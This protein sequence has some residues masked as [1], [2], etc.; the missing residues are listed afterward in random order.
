MSAP[1]VLLLATRNPGKLREL[2]ELLAPLG[3]RVMSP[4]EARWLEDVVE[5]GDTLEANALK[6]ARTA[7]K[8][9]GMAAVAD[10]SG[11]FV[12]S[13]GGAPGVRSAR[14]AGEAQDP[15]AN[16]AKLLD[17]LAG[18]PLGARGAEFRC[19]VALVGEGVDRVFTGS[20]RGRI[21]VVPRGEGGFGY[22]PVFEVPDLGMT[23]AE[24]PPGE[25]NRRSHRGKALA[26]LRAYLAAEVSGK[27]RA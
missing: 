3:V 27:G 15:A 26:S 14:Y 23:F 8:A 20:V 11:L 2:R 22:D 19:A 18:V 10:D 1:D 7:W 24:I 16:C 12:D 13:L 6:K 21:A 9:A 17:S 4:E 5:D 25:K